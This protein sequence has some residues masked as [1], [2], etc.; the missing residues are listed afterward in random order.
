MGIYHVV[1][2]VVLLGTPVTANADMWKQVRA[3]ASGRV[4]NGYIS[5]DWVLAFMYRYMEWGISVAGL[6]QVTVP[7][8]EN[9]NL[10][11]LGFSGHDEYPAHLPDIFAKLCVGQ[12]SSPAPPGGSD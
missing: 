7:G 8:I 3:V 5:S 6:S 12:I 1:D 10:A 4:I 9:V 2:D 11:G